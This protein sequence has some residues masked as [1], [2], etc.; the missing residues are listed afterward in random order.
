MLVG[1]DIIGI[2]S[3]FGIVV[4]FDIIYIIGVLIGMV[5]IILPLVLF[6]L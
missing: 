4:R 2:I 3:I 1:F 5:V 6:C